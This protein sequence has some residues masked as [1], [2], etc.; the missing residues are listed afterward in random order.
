M[1][2]L[3]NKAV[4]DLVTKQFGETKWAEIKAK[5]GLDDETF[6]SMNSYDD[7]VT[8]GLVGAASEVLGMSPAAILEA[9]GEYWTLYT[10]KEGYGE[11][12]KMSGGNL[13]EFMKNLDN[14]HARV[15]LSF[16]DLKPPSFQ[17][18]DLTSDSLNLHYRSERQGLGPLVAGLI[19]G[20]GKMFNTEVE[21]ALLESR[22]SGSDH[23]VFGVKYR[24]AQQVNPAR[25]AA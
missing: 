4:Q 9:F 7:S 13:V 23:D 2:G 5:A 25:S 3:V 8:Y 21:V 17:V 20:L 6:V 10:A 1:Y 19:R 22:E 24:V 11:L 15:G 14:L 12:I 18:T 16:P